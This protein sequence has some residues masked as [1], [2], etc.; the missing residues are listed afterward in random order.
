MMS[1]TTRLFLPLA[2][3]FSV[4]TIQ[5]KV[6]DVTYGKAVSLAQEENWE[7]SKNVF[8]KMLVNRSQEPDVLY[9]AGVVSFKT[10][11]FEQAGAY[12]QSVTEND[13]ASDSLKEQA[14]FN[15]GNTNVELQD[16]KE[17]VKNYEAVLKIN[18]ENEKAK[19]NL[20][21][22]KKMLEQQQQQ[23][24]QQKD[25][26]KEQEKS[27]Q[28]RQQQDKKD[29][30]Q[31]KQG[32]EQQQK[33]Q[34]QEQQ[35]GL[36]SEASAKEDREELDKKEQE[37]S[38]GGDQDKRQD[39]SSEDKEKKDG[40]QPRRDEK[41]SEDRQDEKWDKSESSKEEPDKKRD[42]K[43]SDMDEH[44]KNDKTEK[45]KE[46]D[47]PVPAGMKKRKDLDERTIQILQAIE[48]RDKEGNKEL[49]KA[50]ISKEMVGKYGQNRW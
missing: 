45:E 29:P 4:F 34:K 41:R 48:K 23:Q 43:Q 20:K 27:E 39:G 15:L 16:F 21:I 9:D 6:L 40:K 31:Q 2:F 8:K 46:Q 17:A 11:D 44:D 13:A 12:F 37:Q 24:E 3:L 32:Q 28:D 1:F 30:E 10:N 33:D 5:T 14:H 18:P 49:M 47:Q 42:D 35:D 19:Y 22:V 50:T 7:D 36:S 25:Q 38:S 26:Q